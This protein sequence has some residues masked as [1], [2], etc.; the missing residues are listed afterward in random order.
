MSSYEGSPYKQW[1]LV[2]V[3][4]FNG[5]CFMLIFFL[6]ILAIIPLSKA[7]VTNA[8]E[9][10]SLLG[11]VRRQKSRLSASL[12]Q[13]MLFVCLA[14]SG[15]VAVSILFP[16]ALS[17]F[18]G[19]RVLGFNNRSRREEDRCGVLGGLAFC[20]ITIVAIYRCAQNRKDENG[21]PLCLSLGDLDH[22]DHEPEVCENDYEHDNELLNLC[23]SST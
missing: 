2:F 17:L 22:C 12:R 5:L 10:T 20:F 1:S 7:K 11:F 21:H 16:L 3:R 18:N 6:S 14:I 19:L 15:V 13:I 4:P 8:N 9:G 23:S